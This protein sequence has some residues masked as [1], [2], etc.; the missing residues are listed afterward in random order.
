MELEQEWQLRKV[1]KHPAAHLCRSLA[2]T[3]TQ[4]GL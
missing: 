4:Y 2:L 1:A 3:V